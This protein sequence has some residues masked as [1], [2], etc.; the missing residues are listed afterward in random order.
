MKNVRNIVH[1]IYAQQDF[2]GRTI[3]LS[4]IFNKEYTVNV[5]NYKEKTLYSTKYNTRAEALSYY[6]FLIK[7]N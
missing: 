6:N 5:Y 1:I 3:V 7:K 2:I 4:G